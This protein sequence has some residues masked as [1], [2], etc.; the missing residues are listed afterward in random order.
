MVT[1]RTSAA[2]LL[3]LIPAGLFTCAWPVKPRPEASKPA[4]SYREQV[5]PRSDFATRFGEETPT[6]RRVR[7]VSI[8]PVPMP[9]PTEAPAPTPVAEA[10]VPASHAPAPP[11][12][13]RRIVLV[14]RASLDI[15]ARHHMRKVTYGKRWRCRR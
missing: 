1:S 3:A 4:P 9:M 5:Y 14:R 8:L 12:A 11:P 7:T 6:V 10:P 15:C 2:V 13:R